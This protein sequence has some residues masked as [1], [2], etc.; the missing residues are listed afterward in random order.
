MKQSSAPSKA[1]FVASYLIA[2]I[3]CAIPFHALLTTWAGSNFGHLDLFRIA[4]ELILVPVGLY[5]AWLIIRNKHLQQGLHNWLF[6]LSVAYSGLFVF[7]ATV[8]LAN[9]RVAD[10]AVAYSLITNLRFVWFV[11][12][13]WAISSCNPLLAR[14]WQKIILI[15]AAVVI[16]FGLLQRF[17]LP[18]DFLRHFGYGPDTIEAV[19]TV[20]QKLE[21]R[22]I[23]STLRGANPLGV[24]LILVV[25]TLA[26]YVKRYAWLWLV[27]AAS[28]VTLFFSYSRS[29]WIG[30]LVS[31]L[32]FTWLSV[33]NRKLRQRLLLI[34]AGVVILFSGLTWVLR[35]NDS[36]QNTV[37]H[38][39]ENS[40]SSLSSNEQRASAL[41]TS[42]QEVWQN[43]LGTGPGS[44]GP[45]SFRNNN[46]PRI[47]ENYFIQIAQEVG[48]LGMLLFV[49]IS[50]LTGWALWKR[51]TPLAKI[52]LASLVGITVVNLVSHA[53]VDDTLSLLWW[54]LAGIA[55]S[56]PVILKKH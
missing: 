54:G 44:A 46:Q 11:G 53:W 24:Y 13:V 5:A 1:S 27:L 2:I 33:N 56:T 38:S 23:Q 41:S 30:L 29:A 10:Q 47:A 43:P 20:D 12:I 49:A 3:L 17:V 51:S 36:V 14:S 25:T 19:Q 16:S 35:N 32:T 18:A 15:P 50:G 55:L 6:W 45:A 40:T 8:V 28:L 22:R 7:S 37:F 42:L 26:A 21:F 39:D 34:T 31:L 4:K 9:G 52:L 48:V